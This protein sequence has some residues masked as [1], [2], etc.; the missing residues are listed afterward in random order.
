MVV[1]ACTVGFSSFLGKLLVPEQSPQ[2]TTYHIC[3]YFPRLQS[4]YRFAATSILR[5]GRSVTPSTITGFS[6]VYFRL[7][8]QKEGDYTSSSSSKPNSKH[9]WSN[10]SVVNSC[11]KNSK[12][13]C[14]SNEIVGISTDSNER[15][16]QILSRMFKGGQQC[17]G[18]KSVTRKLEF[19]HK[20]G[21]HRHKPAK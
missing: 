14:L 15:Q 1:R 18:E 5:T 6:E 11:F 17:D 13:S 7:I 10:S 12:R 8:Q 9:N 3:R 20:A 16:E 21:V 4:I 2:N 19:P